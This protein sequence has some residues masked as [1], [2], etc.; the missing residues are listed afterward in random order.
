MGLEEGHAAIV[1]TQ[2]KDS[3]LPVGARWEREPVASQI[4]SRRQNGRTF[5]LPGIAVSVS[6]TDAGMVVV[7]ISRKKEIE[8]T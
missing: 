3:G 6:R 2:S 5:H 4:T 1:V 8:N 7:I